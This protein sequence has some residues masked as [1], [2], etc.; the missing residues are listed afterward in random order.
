LVN[1]GGSSIIFYSGLLY[2]EKKNF[3]NNLCLIPNPNSS[4]KLANFE[5]NFAISFDRLFLGYENTNS[6]S[7][8]SNIINNSPKSRIYSNNPTGLIS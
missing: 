1:N 2:I 8:N 5:N 6:Y 4:V 3:P 7:E